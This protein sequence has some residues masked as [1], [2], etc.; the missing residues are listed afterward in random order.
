MTCAFLIPRA[1]IRARGII[2]KEPDGIV[3]FRGG[4]A[5][6]SPVV[7][8][9]DAV[10]LCELVHHAGVPHIHGTRRAHNQDERFAGSCFL[11]SNRDIP[12]RYRFYLG[13]GDI[14]GRYRRYCC[15]VDVSPGWCARAAGTPEKYPRV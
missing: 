1:S 12:D 8:N 9:D 7:E 15:S 3:P 13:F 11:I 2:G 5:A 4:R 10:V 6:H 14:H